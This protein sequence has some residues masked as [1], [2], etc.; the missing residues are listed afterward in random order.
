[1]CTAA[2]ELLLAGVE[3]EPQQSQ[4][5]PPGPA[6]PALPD[7]WAMGHTPEGQPYYIDHNT[8]TTHW[9]LPAQ[10]NAPPKPV[11]APAPAPQP[12]AQPVPPPVPQPEHSVA[13]T[14][15]LVHHATGEQLP[16]IVRQAQHGHYLFKR[17]DVAQGNLRQDAT[18]SVNH[19]GGEGGAAQIRVELVGG[20]AVGAFRMSSAAC[21]DKGYIAMKG[22]SDWYSVE[23]MATWNDQDPTLWFMI[24]GEGHSPPGWLIA[25][26]A[27]GNPA[28]SQGRGKGHK[29]KGKVRHSQTRPLSELFAIE[30]P[31]LLTKTANSASLMIET[32][33]ASYGGT[34]H[35]LTLSELS[36]KLNKALW[37]DASGQ[38]EQSNAPHSDGNQQGER[39]VQGGA[40]SEGSGKSSPQPP[41]PHDPS[42]WAKS[43]PAERPPDSRRAND[44]FGPRQAPVV[45]TV[46]RPS[47]RVNEGGPDKNAPVNPS[48]QHREYSLDDYEDFCYIDP[49]RKIDHGQVK[50]V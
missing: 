12:V 38:P 36:R 41:Q 14:A 5:L 9:E 35:N 13:Q 1:M 48:S 10:H 33:D 27:K 6:A 31:V 30:S 34:I 20:E 32:E 46:M 3:E 22:L 26:P 25:T 7:G 42:K 29:G 4:P 47:V 11:P 15:L 18:G 49:D 19:H 21:R 28:R 16:C 17:Q 50:L 2:L 24:D 37:I 45:E 8:C 43:G 44:R 39:G 23:A 40:P